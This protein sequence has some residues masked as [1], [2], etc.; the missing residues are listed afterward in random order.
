MPGMDGIEVCRRI[1]SAG[2]T[3]VLLLTAKDEVADLA[4]FLVSDAAAYIT[5]AVMPVDGGMS[6][7]GVGRVG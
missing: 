7:M 4:L 5:G 6:L 2:D 3:P 1:R